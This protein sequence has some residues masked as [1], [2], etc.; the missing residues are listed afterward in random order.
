MILNIFLMVKAHLI[1]K[2]SLKYK[3]LEMHVNYLFDRI[4]FK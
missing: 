2:K 3:T 1:D 4:F